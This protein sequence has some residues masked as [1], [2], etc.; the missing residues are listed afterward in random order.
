MSFIWLLKIVKDLFKQLRTDAPIKY[1]EIA[2]TTKTSQSTRCCQ[3]GL[4]CS[5]HA[6]MFTT[7]KSVE[8]LLRRVFNCLNL[9][10]LIPESLKRL[11]SIKM[12]S[13]GAQFSQLYLGHKK[14]L[15]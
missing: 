11:S 10:D 14:H 1:Y 12:R 7:R 5:T 2:T 13:N 3:N 9:M 8:I 4:F 6:R 15:F